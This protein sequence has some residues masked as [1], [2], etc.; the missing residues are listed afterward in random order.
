MM[1]L[2]FSCAVACITASLFYWHAIC[3][4]G[5]LFTH[6]PADGLLEDFQLLHLMSNAAMNTGVQVFGQTS[7]FI[8]LG[9]IPRSEITGP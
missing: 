5:V 9:Q 2:R 6:S 8:S 3:M 1:L 4:Y 7:V